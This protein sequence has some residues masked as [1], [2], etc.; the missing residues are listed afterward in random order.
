[1]MPKKP[2]RKPTKLDLNDKSTTD[3]VMSASIL[4]D[5]A[6]YLHLVDINLVPIA[7]TIF[8]DLMKI[9]KKKRMA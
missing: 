7:T 2:T 8:I 9:E 1:M 4:L 5:A 6:I 3:R